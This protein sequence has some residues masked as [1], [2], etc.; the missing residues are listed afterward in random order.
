[1]DCEQ[2][3]A[4]AAT[5]KEPLDASKREFVTLLL[6]AKLP[7]PLMNQILD[8]HDR[9]VALADALMVAS[10]NLDLVRYDVSE[11]TEHLQRRLR[12]EEKE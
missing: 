2:A 3:E 11:F 6:D 4:H 10:V 5:A 9:V 8:A 12:G 1:M 7:R